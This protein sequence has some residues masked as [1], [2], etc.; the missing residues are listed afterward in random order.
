[1]YLC[2][3]LQPLS[4]IQK[5]ELAIYT[6]SILLKGISKGLKKCP[7]TC[8]ATSPFPIFL[9]CHW[10]LN[11]KPADTQSSH[12]K[13]E[14]LGAF[15]PTDKAF[16]IGVWRMG[17]SARQLKVSDIFLF[18]CFSLSSG[19][20]RHYNSYKSSTYVRNGMW[21]FLEYQS[22]GLSGF[23]SKDTLS[24]SSRHFHW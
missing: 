20:H 10:D 11:Q 19:L 7:G 13:T 17:K 5:G 21:F 22:G 3:S 24:V 16:Q 2:P 14:L 12:L 23:I 9:V 18:I 4:F 15:E 8:P 1:M 6:L